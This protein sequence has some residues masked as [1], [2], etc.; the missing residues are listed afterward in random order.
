MIEGV[1]TSVVLLMYLVLIVWIR[2]DQI[3]PSKTNHLAKRVGIFVALV[4]HGILA[5]VCTFTADGIDHS[6]SSLLILVTFGMNLLMLLLNV[7]LRHE[8]LL[9]LVFLLT[10][11]GIGLT[12]PIL[13]GTETPKLTTDGSMFAH[14]FL[15]ISAY[16]VLTLAALQTTIF[17]LLQLFLRSKKNLAVVAA[18]PPLETVE[19]LNFQLLST[20]LVVLTLTIISGVIL[21]WPDVGQL[22]HQIHMAIAVGAW[23]LYAAILFGY[24]GVGWRGRTINLFSI[25]A[26]VVLTGTYLGF[27]IS[28]LLVT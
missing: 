4:F 16:A 27:R 13:G 19:K 9:L 1:F 12:T 22:L 3:N 20:G 24:Y 23:L 2:A 28:P 14:I 17:T 8:V 18:L 5:Y 21:Y 25:L 6:I 26:F 7:T 15:S 10:I 11:L